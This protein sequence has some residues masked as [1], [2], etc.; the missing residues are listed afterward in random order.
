MDCILKG[1]S[2]YGTLWAL[3]V[4]GLVTTDVR[5]IKIMPFVVLNAVKNLMHLTGRRPINSKL[6]R[7][8]RF[9]APAAN[10][11]FTTC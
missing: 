4:V 10:D 7:R 5:K 9:F 2:A 1:V 3:S 11:K 8:L 6:C